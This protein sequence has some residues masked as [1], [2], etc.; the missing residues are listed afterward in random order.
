MKIVEKQ[1]NSRMCIICGMDNP[2]GIQA[3][4]YSMEDGSVASIFS[5]KKEHQSYPG[6]VHGG[7]ITAMLDELGLR[8]LWVASP[9]IM[10]VTMSIESRYRKPVPYEVQLKG[11]A[12]ILTNSSRFLKSEAFLTDMDGNVLADAVLKYLKLDI[13]Q[14]QAGVTYH[15]EMCY[16]LPDGLAEL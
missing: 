4:F 13:S 8:A 3:P 2:Y 7:M 11:T 16:Y 1:R 14:I 5:F 15:E 6:R 12:R 10:G 9:E